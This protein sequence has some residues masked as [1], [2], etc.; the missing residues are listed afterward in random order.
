MIS[1]EKSITSEHA[2]DTNISQKNSLR[3]HESSIRVLMMS[4][5]LGHGDG[6][7]HGG[8]T[9]FL[10][11]LPHM[12]PP[13]LHV[14][15]AFFAKRHP[16]SKILEA[17]GIA[18]LFLGRSKWDPRAYKDLVKLIHTHSPQVLH[19][20]GLKSILLGRMASHR[21]GIPSV[22]HVHDSYPIPPGVRHLQQRMGKTTA[23]ALI[24][25][26]AHRDHA[27]KE[28]R[29]PA[30][31]I[32]L[33]QNGIDID[34]FLNPPADARRRCRQELGISDKSPVI[35]V[36]G[37]VVEEKGQAAL[38]R[39]MSDITKHHPEVK[40]LVVGDGPNRTHC[41]NIVKDLGLETT[42]IFTGQ[43]MDIPKLLAA[44]DV[45]AMP[46]FCEEA[47]GFSALEAIASGVPVVAF[48]SGGVPTIVVDG[49]TGILVDRDNIA[50]LAQ[51]I[52]NLLGDDSL[53]KKLGA[54][55]RQ[56]AQT[57]SIKDHVHNLCR[58]YEGVLRSNR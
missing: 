23:A 16:A 38:I 50:G 40:L 29:I 48:N 39:V 5:H 21:C 47:F 56:H 18:P 49:K 30:D 14:T 7:I 51:S 11:T 28:F 31:R 41:E 24:I 52:R 25:C 27:L 19:L 20:S 37:R 17:K 26:E 54:N 44:I 46:S 12:G 32:H 2:K 57:F 33:L 9:Y 34:P 53:R 15:V 45:V 58:I 36:I 1:Q 4:D 43:R 22:V 10:N 35:G 13:D 6:K 55:G 42:V 8:T 3:P